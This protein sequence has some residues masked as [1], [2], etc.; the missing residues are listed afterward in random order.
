M[1][2]SPPELSD[3]EAE[4]LRAFERQGHD[5]LA[6]SYHAFFA[7][8]T[9][10]ATNPL[11]DA[12]GLHPG[13]RLLDVATGPGALAAE[14]ANRGARPFGID[15]SPRRPQAVRLSPPGAH[16]QRIGAVQPGRRSWH[17]PA[18]ALRRHARTGC[19]V[20]GRSS[21]HTLMSYRDIE[22]FP[23]NPKSSTNSSATLSRS[24]NY[25]ER[26]NPHGF[27][28]AKAAHNP[29]L[30]RHS[31]RTRGQITI[32]DRNGLEATLR[33]WAR[34]TSLRSRSRTLAAFHVI[35]HERH[36][37]ADEELRRRVRLL[38]P[39]FRWPFLIGKVIDRSSTQ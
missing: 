30:K 20:S 1:T 34:R 4:R 22:P 33:Q 10:L 11:L 25:A 18:Q 17:G 9:S 26:K 28:K 14:A 27:T 12:V 39:H 7:A 38:K 6:T 2:I 8:V 16:C 37:R 36:G 23:K 5:V 3:S 31:R 21:G 13:T 15:L 35:R 32:V 29:D 24:I 19:C